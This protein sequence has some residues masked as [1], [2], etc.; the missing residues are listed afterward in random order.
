MKTE[1]FDYRLPQELIALRP[2]ERRDG[3]RLLVLDSFRGLVS[4]SAI[5]ELPRLL[6]RGALV[7]ANDTRV[8]PA[9]LCGQR[10]TG[11]KIEVLLVRRLDSAD[12]VC[13][14]TALARANKPL[15]TGDRIGFD[16]VVARVERR[17]ERG[18]VVLGFGGDDGDVQRLIERCGEVPLPPYIKRAPV[19]DD[20]HRYQTVFARHDGSVAAPTAGLHF[21]RELMDD[22]VRAGR[23][24]AFVTLHVGPGTFRPITAGEL[25]DHEM[26]AELYSVSEATVAALERAQEQ[27]RPV[28]AIGTTVVRCLE[29]C[30]LTRGRIEAGDGS[31][32]LFI[33]PGFEFQVVNGLLTNFHLPRSTLLCL[34]SA[35]AGRERIL[36]AYRE[37]VRE[38]YRFYSYGDA[39]LILPEEP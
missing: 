34:V 21:T 18:E 35:L 31:T 32:D 24:L 9:R 12:G 6:P 8:I 20:R 25:A 1:L 38:R 16:G 10:P 11:G 15:Q 28:I 14:W 13:R 39:M 5:V 3:G 33:T 19:V 30:R 29:G 22:V 23:E 36:A 4:H 27:G 17:G 26:D 37:A 2:P 7:V